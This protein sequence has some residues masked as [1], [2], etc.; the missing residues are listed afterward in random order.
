[1]TIALPLLA[2]A[3]LIVAAVFWVRSTNLTTELAE[4]QAKAVSDAQKLCE[5]SQKH[6]Q[7]AGK[8]Q[9]RG[10]EI[11]ELREKQKDLR[12]R[13]NEA[14]VE[15]RKLKDQEDVRID[16]ERA[17]REQALAASKEAAEA[18][19]QMRA[20]R[21]ELAELRSRRAAPRPVPV[22]PAPVSAPVVVPFVNVP[23][24]GGPDQAEL[25]ARLRVEQGRLEEMDLRLRAE[26]RKAAEATRDGERLKAKMSTSEKLYVVQK[27]E[28]ELWKDRY[29]TL[30]QRLNKTLRE[31]DALHR[32]VLAL[33]RRLPQATVEEARAEAVAQTPSDPEVAA[34]LKSEASGVVASFDAKPDVSVPPPSP[35]PDHSS[36]APTEKSLQASVPPMEAQTAALQ[37]APSSEAQ[38]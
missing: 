4:I 20:M 14:Q 13:L 22:E 27:G 19:Q 35:L 9:K 6:E 33:E 30:E 18:S 23:A 11:E 38:S 12:R 25:E 7:K 17:A 3:A 15:A 36:D 10:S 34:S 37:P 28:L 2:L 26:Q 8:D 1:M 32:G 24:R 31:V 29:R 5:L 16:Q 21:A